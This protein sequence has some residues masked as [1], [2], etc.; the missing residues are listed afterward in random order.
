MEEGFFSPL[1]LA[2]ITQS[3]DK[4][5]WTPPPPPVTGAKDE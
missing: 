5:N 3:E 2:Q 1:D 4:K